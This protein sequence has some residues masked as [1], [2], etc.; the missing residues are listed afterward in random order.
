MLFVNEFM[1]PPLHALELF[2]TVRVIGGS[3]GLGLDPE[4]S[5]DEQIIEEVRLMTFA[6]IKQF[7]SDE[8]H[9][10]FQYCTTLDDVFQLRGYLGQ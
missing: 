6:E 4:M 8:V 7:P 9:A 2:F 1:L 5:A 3:L 10:L